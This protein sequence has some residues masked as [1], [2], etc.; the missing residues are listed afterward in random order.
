MYLVLSKVC[1]A[2]RSKDNIIRIENL[3]IE[4]SAQM[5][6]RLSSSKVRPKITLEKIKLV[7]L[8]IKI[9]MSFE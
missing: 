7:S 9:R 1:K 8:L 5:K 3:G 2:L 6:L 4:V